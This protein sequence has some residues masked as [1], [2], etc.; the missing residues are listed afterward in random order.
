[1]RQPIE[2]LLV[3]AR[4]AAKMLSI[5]ERSLWALSAPRGSLPCIRVP[6][7]RLVRYSPADLESWIEAARCVAVKTPRCGGS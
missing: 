4:D 6:G 3:G 2:T 1:V 5:S 7:S